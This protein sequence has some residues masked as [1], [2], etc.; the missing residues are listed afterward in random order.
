M[1]KKNAALLALGHVYRKPNDFSA[2]TESTQAAVLKT[3]QA[4]TISIGGGPGCSDQRLVITDVPGMFDP[5]TPS[6]T[7]RCQNFNGSMKETFVPY[8]GVVRRGV[9]PEEEH[10]YQMSDAV[11]EAVAKEFGA[12]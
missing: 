6:F 7:I 1:V 4:P 12:A 8:A 2:P 10:A 5:C 11:I 9:L 3:P